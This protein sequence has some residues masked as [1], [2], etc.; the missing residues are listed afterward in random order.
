MSYKR[1]REGIQ[2]A[3]EKAYTGQERQDNGQFGA[4]LEGRCVCG[5]RLGE[6]TAARPYV[7]I[8][9]DFG[10]PCDCQK[11]KRARAPK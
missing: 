5:H 2:T 1:G 3:A 7:C 10:P 8:V 6:H 11:F 4:S 9:G